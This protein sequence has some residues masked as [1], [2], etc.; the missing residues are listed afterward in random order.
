MVL[1]R[2][3]TAARPVLKWAGGK[4]RLL[5]QF[6]EMFPAALRAGRLRRYVEPFIGGGAVFFHIAQQC[7]LREA[8]L[9]DVN[10][11]LILAYKVLQRDPELL[12]GELDSLEREYLKL[13]EARRKS[14]YYEIRDSYNASPA[15][16][17]DGYDPLWA[18][19]AARMIF[20][21]K[22]CFNGLY[23]VNRSGH[24]NVPHGRYACPCICDQ[25]NLRAASALLRDATLLCTD[26]TAALDYAD[27]GAFIYYDPPYRPLNPTSNFTAYAAG[28]FTDDDQRRLANVFRSAH[29]AGALQM[30]SN[31]DPRN[32]NPEDDFFE[33][34]Y[35]GFTIS[36]VSAA[37]M[38]N[39][40]TGGRGP[41]SELVIT[42]Y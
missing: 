36:R 9:C 21:N 22:T 37:R 3:R 16:H 28:S 6:E 27:E 5:D 4:G 19:R 1:L 35:R 11:E 24:F 20:L 33:R 13:P 32:E 39:R 41:I 30:L 25:D 31:S 23:R 29:R 18:H 2:E 7:S 17:A 42:N 14:F 40:N 10:P 26:F 38:I 34:L 12:I 8:V 15:A